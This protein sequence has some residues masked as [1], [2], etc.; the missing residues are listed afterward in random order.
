MAKISLR[1]LGSPPDP[2]VRSILTTD[3]TDPKFVFV[4]G[5]G[6]HDLMCGKCRHK[7]AA[8]IA[9]DSVRSMIFKC[10]KCGSFND[11]D[12]LGPN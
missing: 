5:E 8:G 3:S 2:A 12:Q 6:P 11:T 10:P 9:N 4:Q 7:L 1:V